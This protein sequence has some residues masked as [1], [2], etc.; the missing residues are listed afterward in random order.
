M[1]SSQFS[2][3]F[4]NYEILHEIGAG[5]FATVYKAVQKSTGQFVAVK[6]LK[7]SLVQDNILMERFEKEVRIGA[8]MNHPYI[9]RLLDRGTTDQQVP[10]VVFEFIDGTTLKEFINSKERLSPFATKELMGQVLDALSSAHASGVIHGDL[11][12]QNIM[13]SR[14]GSK[15]HVKVLD[16]GVSVFASDTT[17]LSRSSASSMV[18][19]PSY[20]APEQLKGEL[21]TAKSDVY[22]WG[23]LLLECLTGAPA[24][25]GKSIEEIVHK[26]LFNA[27]VDLPFFIHEH[28]IGNLL[29]RVLQ[30]NPH[31]RPGNA[32]ELF[33]DYQSIDFST[34]LIP[35]GSVSA[36]GSGSETIENDLTWLDRTKDRKT[37][38]VLT[39]KVDLEKMSGCKIDEEG[40]D[41]IYHGEIKYC[42]DI[43][44]QF[45]GFLA[46][47]L[48]NY[49]Q[50]Y[51]G[52][53]QV[54]DNDGRLTGRT[55]LEVRNKLIR[56]SKEL[57][58]KYSLKLHV[59]QAIHA[60]LM[61][62]K[63]NQTPRAIVA[64]RISIDLLQQVPS[65][66]ILVTEPTRQLLDAHMEFEKTTIRI[67]GLDTYRI[68]RE[69][70]DGAFSQL[71]Y[72]GLN[73]KMQGR[74]KELASVLNIWNSNTKNT[75]VAILIEGEAGIG[76]S[77][78]VYEVQEEI[79]ANGGSVLEG[80]CL[81]EYRNSSLYPVLE[82]FKK[83]YKLNEQP[84]D[85]SRVETLTSI[86]TN[87]GCEVA[88]E[89]PI[90]C[91]WL[92]ISLKELSS[93]SLILPMEQKQIL[94]GTLKKC[95]KQFSS[96]NRQ[97]FILEDL[98]WA[99]PTTLTFLNEMVSGE[100]SASNLVLLTS[101]P[102]FTLAWT[103]LTLHTV[104][105]KALNA[106]E[107]KLIVEDILESTSIHKETLEYILSNTDGVPFFVEEYT[108][109]LIVEK[110]LLRENGEFRLR[111]DL[112]ITSVPATLKEF[113]HARLD[114][115]GLSKELAQVA[116]A[117]GRETDLEM[118]LKVSGKRE[119]ELT[120]DLYQL[121]NAGIICSDSESGNVFQ[122]RHALFKETAYESMTHAKRREV[123]ATIAG[124]LLQEVSGQYDVTLADRLSHHLYYSGRVADAIDWNQK[125]TELLV[126]KSANYETVNLCTKA[127]SWLPEVAEDVLRNGK[128][129]AIR[130]VLISNLIA[131][132]GYGSIAV[133]QQLDAVSDLLTRMDKPEEMFPSMF[134]L[135]VHYMMQG[136]AGG[137]MKIARQLSIEAEKLGTTKWVIQAT[138]LLAVQL[139]NYGEFTEASAVLE[140]AL[141]I[142]DID[143]H[144]QLVFETG[145]DHE[146][147]AC[148]VLGSVY[149]FTGKVDEIAKLEKRARS[150]AGKHN[151]PHAHTLASM[152]LG[153]SCI[154]YY[155]GNKEEVG[156]NSRALIEHNEKH[157]M[158][159]FLNYG[160]ILHAWTKG[161]LE[162][163]KIAME[164]EENSGMLS[165]RSMWYSVIASLEIEKGLLQE[166]TTRLNTSLDFVERY[167]TDGPQYTSEINR[168]LG[169]ICLKQGNLAAAQHYFKKAL[170]IA[171]EQKA[172]RV[173]NILLQRMNSSQPGK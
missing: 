151:P 134:M 60:G 2:V 77:K 157:N 84:D 140:N 27:Q 161:D 118:L 129:F 59:C 38:T 48:A 116:A 98:H 96:A 102:E 6:V 10:F 28:A 17:S 121:S 41:E 130:Q 150:V 8:E 16:F 52:Y 125:T 156:K 138:T 113:L 49:H 110:K 105:L 123:H 1:N 72:S 115:L 18:G 111:K 14:T 147:L 114:V 31:S 141:A 65:E 3:D 127:L 92:G 44:Q 58:E 76:K 71:H 55:A 36:S 53:P 67:Q 164:A 37:V 139:F 94:F 112:L 149:A 144:E 162:G 34:L 25:T 104:S 165:M 29:Q 128:E 81:P 133:S 100:Y 153:L 91:A 23:L 155:L 95:L 79:R 154:Y 106:T 35:T 21:P 168:M 54:R 70:S 30:K 126:K 119:A 63:P 97:L 69:R 93:E 66:E 75:G 33:S 24:I 132:E 148:T 46:G 61:V 163:A 152:Y 26:Q 135:S 80:R 85:K 39:I 146:V 82:L 19:T 108:R 40:L 143:P 86:L 89:L 32:R 137:A 64:G 42:E 20:S 83:V 13:V 167:Q 160:K 78:L 50:I 68:V 158:F 7:Q 170:E 159:M 124:V 51:F 171:K 88:I 73:R 57:E 47:S 43:V 173:E 62:S 87:A 15:M 117:I 74:S 172:K 56:R 169:E 131:T 101:R 4:P 145:L 22:S 120:S 166:A 5:N 109:M 9:V 103:D 11:K 12:P 99:D 45:E 122:F 136:D 107:S 90:V 142:F